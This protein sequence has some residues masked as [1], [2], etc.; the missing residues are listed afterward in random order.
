MFSREEV[1]K[2]LSHLEGE[3]HLMASLLYGSGLRLAECLTLRIKDIDFELGGIVVRSGKGDNDQST[4]W[5]HVLIPSLKRQ[6]EKTKIKLEENQS[7][8]GF[9][10]ASI[11]EALERK[12]PYAPMELNWQYFFISKD[13]ALDPRSGKLKQHHH[14]E[15]FLQ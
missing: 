4:L 9:S 7:V 3:I 15:S 5:P 11:P 14:H 2:V 12:Y 1:K 6:I 10:G 13:L 8:A